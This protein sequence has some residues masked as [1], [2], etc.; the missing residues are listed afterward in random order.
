MLSLMIRLLQTTQHKS[1]I[2][3]AKYSGGLT[4][5]VAFKVDPS[6][7]MEN[8]DEYEPTVVEQLILQA[9]ENSGDIVNLENE[10]VKNR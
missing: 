10:V 1:I 6:I 3:R 4:P 7:P 9:N 5:S 2:Y 8:F